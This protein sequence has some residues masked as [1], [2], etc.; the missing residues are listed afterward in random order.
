MS[1]IGAGLTSYNR[2][3][4]LKLFKKQLKDVKYSGLL[5]IAEDTSEN[6]RGVAFRKNECLRALKD[7]DYI[8]L[9]DDDCFPISESWFNL[10]IVYHNAT[11]Q[12][13]FLYLK[14]TA[15]IRKVSTIQ[16]VNIYDNCGGCFMFL[17]KEV[18]EK[19]GAFD[20]SY[21]MFGFEHADY[22]KRVFKSGL[23]T[24]GEYLCPSQA[25]DYI[26]SLDFDNHLDYNKQINH[27]PSIITSER[28]EYINK[29]SMVWSKR[30][31]DK[32]F[33]PL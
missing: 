10:F 25:S 7:C 30:S 21:G 24:M 8:F 4:H 12:H 15:T 14:E 18:I 26:Y 16:G 13:H 3:E 20:E 6:R 22:S 23:N 1:K 17:T 27:V 29:S 28:I 11:N 31:E 5:H 19:V 32:I 9:F 33:I 2:P